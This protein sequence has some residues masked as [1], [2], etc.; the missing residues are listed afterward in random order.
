MY[1]DHTDYQLKLGYFLLGNNALQ[2]I[3]SKYKKIL[4]SKWQVLKLYFG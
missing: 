3:L 1:S 4:K 2:Y